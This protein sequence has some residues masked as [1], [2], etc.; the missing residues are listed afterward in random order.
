M[1]APEQR[2]S[3]C[4]H[5]YISTYQSCPRQWFIKYILGL[6]PVHTA[7]YLV[8]GKALH[9]TAAH[10]LTTGFQP[11]GAVAKWMIPCF[12]GLA[13]DLDPNTDPKV[14]C[15]TLARMV[16]TAIP[17]WDDDLRRFRVVAVEDELQPC[18]AN[19]FRMTMRLDAVFEDKQ[20]GAVWVSERKN[21]Q[22]S[23]TGMMRSVANSD[24]VVAY[25]L[26]LKRTCSERYGL[27][28]EKVLGAIPEVSYVKGAVK[29]TIVG[30]PIIPTQWQLDEYEARTIGLLS[31]IGN[32]LTLLAE[33]VPAEVLFGRSPQ[34][35][36][37]FL[38]CDYEPICKRHLDHA[39]TFE[40]FRKDPSIPYEGP[41]ADPKAYLTW[42]KAQKE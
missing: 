28:P 34:V 4:G 21:T 19:G 42:A 36:S 9:E 39:S 31:E 25:T 1:S 17:I 2:E 32:K 27:D 12:K 33:G 18:L 38:R 23:D 37:G 40:G 10:Y 3:S 24:Q 15:N 5:H 11:F 41:I 6:L 22:S 35:C 30:D 26:G 7:S 29:R 20:T 16:R 8:L 13:T 14:L